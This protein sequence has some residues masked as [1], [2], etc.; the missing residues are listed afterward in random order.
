MNQEENRY[1]IGGLNRRIKYIG[2][3]RFIRAMGR[4]STFIFLPLILIQ[5]YGLSFIEA[6][7][8]QGFATLLMAIVQLYAGH[9]T[10]RIGRRVLMVLIPIPN[11]FFFLLMFFAIH[12]HYGVSVLVGSWFA[13]VLVNA[14]QYPALQAAVADLSPDR[15]R[16]SAFT[17]VRI[18]VNLG[19]AVGPIMGGFLASV[20][21]EYIF[22]VASIASIIEVVVLYFAVPETYESRESGASV[23]FGAGL[24]RALKSR[25]FLYFILVGII[26][27]FFIRQSSISLTVY[28]VVLNNLSYLDLGIVFA[29]NGSLVVLLQFR[30]LRLMTSRWTAIIW[31]GIGTIV[32]AVSF[33]ILGISAAFLVI[34]VFMIVST[35]GENFTTPTTNTIVTKAAP[36]SLRGTY[37][38][39]YSFFSS[40]GS[41]MGSVLGLLMLTLFQG[42]TS[43][44][45]LIIG[46][47]T[48]LVSLLYFAMNASYS[49]EVRSY[50]EGHG[51]GLSHNS[52]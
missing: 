50:T 37:I 1:N 8:L 7:L 38:G 12:L 42:I 15:D 47:G 27:Q 41:F 19:V 13:T 45:W 30:M 2:I 29:V 43:L 18:M 44:F 51:T 35:V 14:L 17:L 46:L 11:V 33:L 6:G 22:L 25:F 36:E 3:T 16:M 31:R 40:I 20:G 48:G 21:F 9:L 32:W 24:R 5:F 34:L 26:F 23:D 52:E 28:A 49:S 10:D 4:S 39:A